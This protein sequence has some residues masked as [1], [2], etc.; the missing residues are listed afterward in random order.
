MT[1]LVTRHRKQK[2]VLL[3]NSGSLNDFGEPTLDAAV[4]IDVRWEN[5]AGETLNAGNDRVAT[6]AKVVVDQ[7]ITIGSILWRG[8]LAD[9]SATTST[10]FKEVVGVSKI[11]DIKGRKYRR[12]VT[13]MKH[14]DRLPTL[15]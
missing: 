5:K 14:S 7:D 2:A 9:F 11:P 4:E 12:V 15:A 8:E 10:D 13:L 3:M 6:E 1:R